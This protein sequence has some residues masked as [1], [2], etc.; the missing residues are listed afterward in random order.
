MSQAFDG[1][2]DGS[3]RLDLRNVNGSVIMSKSK[4]RGRKE[5][6]E[7]NETHLKNHKSLGREKEAKCFHLRPAP[8]PS[9]SDFPSCKN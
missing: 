1:S 9:F 8:A 2:M 6:E 4:K 3:N 5:E 7:E